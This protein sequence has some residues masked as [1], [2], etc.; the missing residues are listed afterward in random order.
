MKDMPFNLIASTGLGESFSSLQQVGDLVESHPY[1]SAGI[2]SSVNLATGNFFLRDFQLKRQE[3][4]ELLKIGYIYNSLAPTEEQTWRLAVGRQWKQLPSETNNFVAIALETDGHETEYRLGEHERYFAPLHMDGRP[5]LFHEDNNGTPR[6]VWIDPATHTTEYYDKTG[7][8]L[9]RLDAAKRA[10]SFTYQDNNVKIVTPSEE[11]YEIKHNDNT[12]SICLNDGKQE[13][14]LH[15]YTFDE[16]RRLIK[17]EIRPSAENYAIEY[18]YHEIHPRLVT[19]IKQSDTTVLHVH[20]ED[21]MGTTPSPRVQNIKMGDAGQGGQYQFSYPVLGLKAEI[22]NGIGATIKFDLDGGGHITKVSRP[23]GYQLKEDIQE[24]TQYEYTNGQLTKTIYP[25]NGIQEKFYDHPYGLLTEERRP[26]GQVTKYGYSILPDIDKL[27]RIEHIQS[28]ADAKSQNLVTYRVYET[29]LKA[30]AFCKLRFEISP[31]GQVT[32]YLYGKDATPLAS[33]NPIAKKTYLEFFTFPAPLPPQLT[34]IDMQDWVDSQKEDAFELTEYKNNPQ[35]LPYLRYDYGKLDEKGQGD[36]HAETTR[37]V[38]TIWN[39]AGQLL[40]HAIKIDATQTAITQQEFDNLYRLTKLTDAAEQITTYTYDDKAALQTVLYPNGKTI[41]THSLTSNHID[42]HIEKATTISANEESI[43]QTRTTSIKNDKAGHPSVITLPDGREKIHFYDLQDRLCFEVSPTGIIIEN[44]F[45]NIY[46][47]KTTIHYA[48]SIRPSSLY[49]DL[50]EEKLPALSKLL[51]NLIPLQNDADNHITYQCYDQSERLCY[52]IDAEK[53]VVEHRY[54]NLDQK[55]DTIRYAN[56]LN[57]DEFSALLTG[58]PLGRTP[59]IK[60]DQWTS[61]YYDKDGNEIGNVDPDNWVTEYQRNAAGR[62]IKKIQYATPTNITPEMRSNTD[63]ALI[64][65]AA[66]PQQDACTH[67]FYDGQGRIIANVTPEGFLITLEYYANG[68]KKSQTQYYNKLSSVWLNNP[69]SFPPIPEAHS[70]DRKTR[71]FYDKKGNLVTSL[72]SDHTVVQHQYDVMGK[73]IFDRTLDERVAA[74]PNQFVALAKTPELFTSI[75]EEMKIDTSQFAQADFVRD[76]RHLY[77]GWQQLTHQ[78]NPF[79]SQL[80]TRIEIDTS[81]SKEQKQERIEALWKN[82]SNYRQYDESGLLCR[83]TN[84]LNHTTFYYYDD[85]RRQTHTIDAEGGVIEHVYDTFNN[86]RTTRHYV[87]SLSPA[88]LKGLTGGFISPAVKNLLQ[89]DDVHDPVDSYKYDKRDLLI[90]HTDPEGN[91]SYFGHNAF[92]KIQQDKLPVGPSGAIAS[93]APLL[94]VEHDYNGRNLETSTLRIN[95]DGQQIRGRNIYENLYGKVTQK[96]DPEGVVAHLSYDRVGNLISHATQLFDAKP[97]DKPIVDFTRQYDAINRLKEVKDALNN[98]TV[99]EYHQADL[100]HVIQ[101]PISGTQQLTQYNIFQEIV[102]SSDAT[103]QYHQK[104][105]HTPDGEIATHTDELGYVENYEYDTE[106]QK[107]TFTN[108]LGVITAWEYNDVGHVKNYTENS[109]DPNNKR[110]TSYR[111]DGLY[112]QVEIIDA[113]QVKIKQTFDRNSLLLEEKI[114]P[115]GLNLIT[116]YQYNAQGKKL[117]QISGDAVTP[118]QYAVQFEVDGFNRATGK[119]IDP[120]TD[121]FPEALQLTTRNKLDGN[122]QVVEH[123]DPNK[124]IYWMIY[125]EWGRQRFKITANG[126]ID[127][128]RYDAA[129]QEIAHIVYE[130]PFDFTAYPER[131]SLAVMMDIAKNLANQNDSRLYYFRDQNGRV[132]FELNLVT[133]PEKSGGFSTKAIVVEN[134]YDANSYRIATCTYASLLNLTDIPLENLPLEALIKYVETLVSVDD[135]HIY[136]YYDAQGYLC[137]TIDPEHY[138]HEQRWDAEKQLTTVIQYAKQLKGVSP[139]W[140]GISIDQLKQQMLEQQI[141]DALN[142]QT[143]YYVFDV[144]GKPQFNVD[145]EGNVIQF[146]HDA[147]NNLTKAIKFKD[148]LTTLFPTY[149]Q[150]VENLNTLNSNKDNDR[151]TES[152]FDAANRCE[153]IIDPLNFPEIFKLNALGGIMT[154]TDRNG[155]DWNFEYDRAKRQILKTSPKRTVTNI[156]VSDNIQNLIATSD[157]RVVKEYRSYDGNNNVKELIIDY[158]GNQERRITLQHNALNLVESTSVENVVIDNPQQPASFQALPVMAATIKT[159]KI[160]NTQGKEIVDQD[161]AGRYEFHI[162]NAL[163]RL[164]Y[165][166]YNEGAVVGFAY[167]AFGHRISKIKY[168]NLLN[169]DLSKYADTG[170]SLTDIRNL[171]TPSFNDVFTVFKN[172]SRGDWTIQKTGLVRKSLDLDDDLVD[173]LQIFDANHGSETIK[174]G[175]SEKIR[176]L[177]AFQQPILIKKLLYSDADPAKETWGIER[178]WF[179]RCNNIVAKATAQRATLNAPL[180]YHVKRTYLNAFFEAEHEIDYYNADSRDLSDPAITL[181]ILDSDAKLSSKDLELKRTYDA[182]G[183]KRT[184]TQCHVAWDKVTF[185]LDNDKYLLQREQQLDDYLTTTFLYTNTGLDAGYIRSDGEATHIFYNSADQICGHT[186]ISRRLQAEESSPSIIPLTLLGLNAH[187]QIVVGT[188]Y[189]SGANPNNLK[190]PLSFD[191]TLDKVDIQHRDN[192]GLVDFHQNPRGIIEAATY[193]KGGEKARNWHNTPLVTNSSIR[194]DEQVIQYDPRGRVQATLCKQDNVIIASKY[195]QFDAFGNT[196]KEGPDNQTWPVYNDIDAQ[197][198]IWRTNRA[199]NLG[200]QG[201]IS[202]IMLRNAAGQKTGEIQAQITDLRQQTSNNLQWLISQAKTTPAPNVPGYSDVELT[203][204]LRDEQGRLLQT[205]LPLTEA[206]DALITNIPLQVWMHKGLDADLNKYS[207]SWVAPPESNVIPTFHC[208]QQPS[209]QTLTVQPTLLSGRYWVDVSTLPTGIYHYDIAY[210]LVMPDG[211]L[212]KTLYTTTGTVGIITAQNDATTQQVMAQVTDDHVLNL[213]GNIQGISS[214]YLYQIETESSGGEEKYIGEYKVNNDPQRP[215]FIDFATLESG[216]PGESGTYLAKPLRAGNLCPATLPFIINT[217][218]LPAVPLAREI[219]ANAQISTDGVEGEL[220]LWETL[221]LDFQ[222]TPVRLQCQFIDANNAPQVVD[223]EIKAPA[224][225][226]S[227]ATFNLPAAVKTMQSVTLTLKISPSESIMLYHGIIPTPTQESHLTHTISRPRGQVK[228]TSL[229]VHRPYMSR[230]TEQYDFVED[231]PEEDSFLIASVPNKQNEKEIHLEEYQPNASTTPK[232]WVCG[233]VQL[234]YLRSATEFKETSTILYQDVSQGNNASW[235][236]LPIIDTTSN[237]III[238]GN[239]LAPGNYPVKFSNDDQAAIYLLVFSENGLVFASDKGSTTDPVQHPRKTTYVLNVHGKIIQETKADGAIYTRDY[240]HL[241]KMISEAGPEV[242]YQDVLGNPPT[243]FL[244]TT[245]TFYDKNGFK[246]GK[247][248]PAGNYDLYQLNA[249]GDRLAHVLGDGTIEEKYILD[250][251]GRRK[252][253]ITMT[254]PTLACV[255]Q[256]FDKADNPVKVTIPNDDPNRNS[257]Q[258]LVHEYRY[259]PVNL[260]NSYIDPGQNI[261]LTEYDMNHNPLE[262]RLPLGHRTRRRYGNNNIL[263]EEQT[264]DENGSPIFTLNWTPDQTGGYFGY[265]SNHLDGS[266]VLYTL[267][268]NK[269]WQLKESKSTGNEKHGLF[270]QVS[271][272][273]EVRGSAHEQVLVDVYTIN[274]IPCPDQSLSYQY[275]GGRQLSVIDNALDITTFYTYDLADRRQAVTIKQHN[276]VLH[277]ADATYDFL[278]RE[279]ELH[280]NGLL[281]GEF[282]YDK[283][284]NRRRSL[285]VLKDEAIE[286]NQVIDYWFDHDMA[287]RAVIFNGVLLDNQVNIDKN[288]GVRAIYNAANQRCTEYTLD[289]QK[290]TVRSDYAYWLS[291]ELR[292]EIQSTNHQI[293]YSQAPTGYRRSRKETDNS[294]ETEELITCDANLF[295]LSSEIKSEKPALTDF[296]ALSDGHQIQIQNT[297]DPTPSNPDDKPTPTYSFTNKF[298]AYDDFKLSGMQGSTHNEYGDRSAASEVYRD[299]NGN[300]A[301]TIGTYDPNNNTDSPITTIFITGPEGLIYKKLYLP[302]Q[303]EDGSKVTDGRYD[304]VVES[305]SFYNLSG[306]YVASYSVQPFSTRPDKDKVLGTMDYSIV[307]HNGQSTTLN[308]N[309]NQHQGPA[310]YFDETMNIKSTPTFIGRYAQGVQVDITQRTMRA[311]YRDSLG[312]ARAVANNPDFKRELETEDYLKSIDKMSISAVPQVSVVRATDTFASLG[313]SLFGTQQDAESIMA[314]AAH[315][316]PGQNPQAGTVI[317]TPQFIPSRANS[318]NYSSYQKITNKIVG[319]LAPHLTFAPPPPPSSSCKETI[320]RVAIDIVAIYIGVKVG[321]EVGGLVTV[322]T[323]NVVL[324]GIVGAVTAAVVTSAVDYELQDIATQVGLLKKVSK[325][326]AIMTGI[327]AGV[328][329]GIGIAGGPIAETSGTIAGQMVGAAVENIV[330]QLIEMSYEHNGVL[331]NQ[332]FNWQELLIAVASGA[333]DLPNVSRKAAGSQTNYYFINLLYKEINA[334]INAV[335]SGII[336]QEPIDEKNLAA[337]MLGTAIGNAVPLVLEDDLLKE[338]ATSLFSQNSSFASFKNWSERHEGFINSSFNDQTYSVTG[339]NNALTAGSD[340]FNE[341]VQTA[342]HK[343][344]TSTNGKSTALPLRA[345]DVPDYLRRPSGNNSDLFA[346]DTYRLMTQGFFP[347]AKTPLPES[348]SQQNFSVNKNKKSSSPLMEYTI[349]DSGV[350]IRKDLITPRTVE[351][352]GQKITVGATFNGR[353][354]IKSEVKV[355]KNQLKFSAKPVVEANLEYLK[356][357]GTLGKFSL[358]SE[359]VSDNSTYVNIDPKEKTISLGKKFNN[360]VSLFTAS[361]TITL[362]EVHLPLIDAFVQCNLKVDA[363]VGAFGYNAEAGVTITPEHGVKVFSKAALMD[364]FGIGVGEDCSFRLNNKPRARR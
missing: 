16:Q 174:P 264:C 178:N 268:Y 277:S 325:K 333:I 38:K 189:A 271:K 332:D 191:N 359:A 281:T 269:K 117:N 295:Q 64:R 59:N 152:V 245:L 19:A 352:M 328:T 322:A 119:I 239:S 91:I 255:E 37:V 231:A 304:N 204:F 55:S 184:E 278:G 22:R 45:N 201:G 40:S 324:G 52:E 97:D 108:K 137:F 331:R 81:L 270:I 53:F 360:Y 149:Q 29:E 134:S 8:L 84:S 241:N 33:G 61:I 315:S 294:K 349:F 319:S 11:C 96:I 148:K 92:E 15:R 291:G 311:I 105:T 272:T 236:N 292:S 202:T 72:R 145:A 334:C 276:E 303:Y 261:W 104:W 124:N 51:D 31:L 194:I 69:T 197:G 180:T 44:Q 107:L 274:K 161:E 32:E 265:M 340:D 162:Y 141:A 66:N 211:S 25:N 273:T 116:T 43:E 132:R 57:Q 363:H 280:N 9:E 297:Y 286:F 54:N 176:K 153:R 354:G 355:E 206:G 112:R 118:N 75:V 321:A 21:G 356:S 14:E 326:E 115:T 5:F 76:N 63:F 230:D 210:N 42:K 327:S 290:N 313:Q 172:D 35:G 79:I 250:G 164:I 299:P 18:A 47:V 275:I 10:T 171:L 310:H 139:S 36:K 181:S 361:G 300:Y 258:S 173:G 336:M 253:K 217:S 247:Q 109:G 103:N 85:E 238:N 49:F 183:K 337:H 39:S 224:L 232:T 6:W 308:G 212:G 48:Q 317:I 146:E 219:T 314:S 203:T 257:G 338:Y 20:Y 65:P 165:I 129:G 222:Q 267:S 195:S 113:R 138:L 133:L 251:F 302:D 346:S 125:D 157:E 99:H 170:I 358:K 228:R 167:N 254:Q 344:V 126:T 190:Q 67:H 323:R 179:D 316:V 260:R 166:V 101:F 214:V 301:G 142:D 287:D 87:N 88:E 234:I 28:L 220:T 23:K 200:Q 345:T 283:N 215:C 12:V 175:H 233:L 127:E 128:K 160:Y 198:Q 305:P 229:A 341:D 221:P 226:G 339:A 307:N 223:T 158:Q 218:I 154:Q 143:Q 168:A 46:G 100:T 240:N 279:V 58:N 309:A 182:R 26:N 140:S 293:F 235:K 288:Q 131:P 207:V 34:L 209:G 353:A 114:D 86:I 298:V 56:A 62:I 296:T 348:Q 60:Q 71:Y 77:D 357:Q 213:I 320:T 89:P 13:L 248:L 187:G 147:N 347:S 306:G 74:D 335:I 199:D 364:V 243:N 163:Q 7:L 329:A 244:P 350:S 188:L 237:G 242:K 318:K 186:G 227:S 82:Q 192:R 4:N 83:S 185:Q 169:V 150:L 208:Q 3:A 1:G 41:A 121:E 50:A 285:L 68:W 17:S 122:H 263:I 351:I 95:A 73:V 256:E 102:G 30:N 362:P 225:V 330:T 110:T 80:I 342:N 249:A 106:G 24:V 120:L 196:I 98:K 216:E 90:E 282:T 252:Q 193:T 156:T 312:V 111:L 262:T 205:N 266:G 123:C 130:N 2:E 135:Q 284:G 27:I 94:K 136:K 78:A 144:F 70:E 93:T 151:I 259:N 289:D 343:P 246:V 177:N 159:K 155:Y